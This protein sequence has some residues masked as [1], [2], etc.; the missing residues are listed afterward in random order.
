[1]ASS[2]LELS[3]FKNYRP[4]VIIIRI[5]RII[6]ANYLH[7]SN[8]SVTFAATKRKRKIIN[9]L[10]NATMKTTKTIAR[11]IEHQ[12][13][14]NEDQYMVINDVFIKG[15]SF[16]TSQR[17]VLIKITGRQEYHIMQYWGDRSYRIIGCLWTR[18]EAYD[19]LK[20]RIHASL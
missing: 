1:M 10:N 5:S 20:A 2:Y 16:A 12:L 14:I 18:D 8:N 7:D 3:H 17:L 15:E 11:L 4:N 19:E 13:R 6:F 9:H